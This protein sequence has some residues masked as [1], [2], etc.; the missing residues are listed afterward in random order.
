M[1]VRRHARIITGSWYIHFHIWGGGPYWVR[2]LQSNKFVF[3]LILSFKVLNMWI[4]HNWI[5]VYYLFWWVQGCYHW[6]YNPF[7]PMDVWFMGFCA[8]QLFK[9]QFLFFWRRLLWNPQMVLVFY[10]GISSHDVFFF[11]IFTHGSLP[12]KTVE[13]FWFGCLGIGNI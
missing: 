1:V 2:Q 10:G 3:I 11:T 7:G 8:I 4:F 6:F 13:A 5:F 9:V 12:I